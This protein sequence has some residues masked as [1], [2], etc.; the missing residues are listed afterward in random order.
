MEKAEKVGKRLD[1]IDP[2]R[3]RS[4]PFDSRIEPRVILSR[5]DSKVAL[6]FYSLSSRRIRRRNIAIP[7]DPSSFT[8]R[9]IDPVFIRKLINKLLG[10][11]TVCMINSGVSFIASSRL[12]DL[13]ILLRRTHQSVRPSTLHNQHDI[14]LSSTLLYDTSDFNEPNRVQTVC[15]HH[16]VP[17]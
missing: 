7:G 16:S 6:P 3:S 12:R 1:A 13:T 2:I 4:I 15:P 11:W 8:A 5:S 10:A 17:I 14:P 9:V